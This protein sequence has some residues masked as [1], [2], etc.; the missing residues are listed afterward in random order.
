M[1]ITD[2]TLEKINNARAAKGFGPLTKSQAMNLL[3]ARKNALE[4][5]ASPA[6]NIAGRSA[7]DSMFLMHFLIGYNTGIMM[8]SA[9]GIAGAMIHNNNYKSPEPTQSNDTQP[10]PDSFT[11]REETSAPTE[12]PSSSYSSSTDS[13]SSSYDSGSSSGSYDSGSSSGGSFE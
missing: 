5:H 2:E 9:G 13:G 12:T 8:P 6:Q 4:A 11:P 3:A 10:R 1:I 7:D